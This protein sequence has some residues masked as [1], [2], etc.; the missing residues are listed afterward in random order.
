VV[1]DRAVPDPA[2]TLAPTTVVVYLH[3]A[4]DAHGMAALMADLANLGVVGAPVAGVQPLELAR[5]Q[6]TPAAQR[7]CDASMRHL[8]RVLRTVPP[9]RFP[10][11]PGDTEPSYRQLGYL[12]PATW[13]AARAVAARERLD[14][15]PVVLAAYAVALARWTGISPVVVMV[16]VSNRFR[17]GLAQA[18]TPLAQVSPCVLD[19]AEVTL[20]EAV[21]RAR[22]ATIGAYKHAY[23]DPARRVE[24]LAV[25]ARERGV[26][27]DL[28]C[29]FNDRRGRGRPLPAGPVEAALD[30]AAAT[31]V[32]GEPAVVR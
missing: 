9:H 25:V 12:S 23:Y 20:A 32:R 18:V 19:V 26:E 15:S 11:C 24:L 27:V 13:L 10:S 3:L 30:P 31:G 8:E 7:Q 22:Q 2:T 5:R 17:P 1:P 6:Q 29:F 4:L 14:T 16:A 21:T 28:S